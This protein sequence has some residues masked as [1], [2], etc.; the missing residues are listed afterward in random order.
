MTCC[1][2]YTPIEK[3]LQE[4]L[5]DTLDPRISDLNDLLPVASI[6]TGNQVNEESPLPY[7]QTNVET[8]RPLLRT[9]TSRIDKPLVRVQIWHDVHATGAAMRDAFIRAIDNRDFEPDGLD[10][11]SIR[12]SNALAI[13]EDDGVWQFL[14]DFELITQE[15][16]TCQ[17]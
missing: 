15:V 1:V 6:V 7:A 2:D 12:Y 11:L 16:C 5:G 8:S 3:A 10:V 9:N 13:Q 4:I 14:I 17:S